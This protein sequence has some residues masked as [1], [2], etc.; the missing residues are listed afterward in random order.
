MRGPRASQD[1]LSCPASRGA[2][3]PL[4]EHR[5]LQHHLQLV[6][7]EISRTCASCKD[8]FQGKDLFLVGRV[9]LS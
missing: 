2:P 7:E 1:M 9:V 5:I 3:R 8:L 4:M 6:S